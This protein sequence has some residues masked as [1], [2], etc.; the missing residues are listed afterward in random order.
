MPET[1]ATENSKWQTA[2]EAK[3]TQPADTLTQC[4]VNVG[5]TLDQ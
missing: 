3:Y 4:W 1:P 5:P 2:T